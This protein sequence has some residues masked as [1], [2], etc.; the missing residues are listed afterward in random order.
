MRLDF[1]ERAPKQSV[2]AGYIF[3]VSQIAYEAYGRLIGAE[4]IR[5][6]EPVNQKLINY[7]TSQDVGFKL[8]PARQGNPH[9]LVKKL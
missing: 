4:F 3:T 2:Y 6:V 9:Y 1:I 7:Y 8:M 5:I